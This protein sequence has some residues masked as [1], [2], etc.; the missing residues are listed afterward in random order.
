[1]YLVRARPIL[2][3][4]AR[5]DECVA[6]P[7]AGVAEPPPADV[8]HVGAMKAKLG[9]LRGPVDDATERLFLQVYLSRAWFQRDIL[10]MRA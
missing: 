4:R 5:I 6:R 10:K 8:D 7:A 2:F 3:A 9:Q 1:M